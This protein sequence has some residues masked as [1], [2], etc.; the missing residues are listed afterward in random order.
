[1]PTSK[2]QEFT[3][4]GTF[5]VPTGVAAVWLTMIGGG[6]SGSGV[7][8]LIGSGGGGGGSGEFC[9]R[10]PVIVTSGG[11][12][13]VTAGAGGAGTS[14]SGGTDGGDSS[15]SIWFAR[16]GKHGLS[17]TSV[18]GAGGGC[19]GGIGGPQG[20][21]ADKFSNASYELSGFTGGVGG[22]G[23]VSPAGDTSTG[24]SINYG[25]SFNLG[26][27]GSSG[28]GAPSPWG[29]GAAGVASQANGISATATC[30][31]AGG[32]GAGRAYDGITNVGARTGGSG[33]PG[34]VLVEWE[35]P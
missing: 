24:V 1:M 34:Y 32:G 19:G 33:A 27:A 3:S 23:G 2:S 13:A 9:M 28:P 22:A 35:A 31:G 10:L 8:T 25:P 5:N 20:F 30:Y 14:G 4:S 7:N 26:T 29:L 12:V 6:G 11:T 18:G 17:N 15:F 21:L 16:G